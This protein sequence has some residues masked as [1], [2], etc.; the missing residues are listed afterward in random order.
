[1]SY[2]DGATAVESYSRNS[3]FGLGFGTGMTLG[4]YV[5][6]VRDLHADPANSLFQHEYGHYLQSQSS[7]WFY[8]SKYAIPS[9]LSSG[10]HGQNPVE[11]DA[12]I[13]A[14]EYF[15]KKYPGFSDWKFT[16]KNANTINGYNW[17]LPY[18][19]VSNQEALRKGKLGLSWYDWVMS[20]MNLS[21]IPIIPGLV[22]TLILNNKY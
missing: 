3:L 6:G 20:P 17:W 14:F 13:R 7:G 16:G 4:S 12:N 22:N 15:N 10:T 19:D 5:N 11:Q 21:F 1:V 8:L 2:Y 9:A 18:D